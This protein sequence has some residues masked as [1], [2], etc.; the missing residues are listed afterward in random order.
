MPQK[1]IALANAAEPQMKDVFIQDSP[2][3][4]S[5]LK[6]I[7]INNNCYTQTDRQTVNKMNF[8]FDTF[9]SK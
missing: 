6:S 9:K 5:I 3:F 1:S 8:I 7:N 2:Y 4:A